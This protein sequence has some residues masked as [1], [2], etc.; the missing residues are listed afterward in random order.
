MAKV[1]IVGKPNVG[2]STLFNALIRKNKSL[3]LNIPGTTRDRIFEYGN[4]SG[5]DILFIDTGGFYKTGEL[6]ENINE[7]VKHA[8][9]A[10]DVVIIVFDLTTPLSIEDEEIFKYVLKKNKKYILIANKTDV[11]KQEFE[12][13]YYKFGDILKVSAAHRKNIDVLKEKIANL[14]ESS[15]KRIECDARVAIVGRSNVGKSS[16]INAILKEN[17]SV[18]SDRVGTTTDSID[19]PFYYREHCLMLVDTAGIRR[20]AKTKKSL[21]KL[22]SIFSIFAID[23]SDICIVLIDASEGLT[24]TDKHIIN[25]VIE[26]NKGIIIALNKWDMIKD[27]T[28]DEYAKVIRRE[29]PMATHAEILHISAKEGKNIKKL[30]NKV[31]TV[32][33]KC[34]NRIPTHLLN[35]KLHTI[36]K[37]NAPFSRKGKEIKLKYITQVDTNPPHFVIFTN[38]P[39]DIEDTY[40]RYIRNSLYKLFDFKGCTIKITYRRT[41]NERAS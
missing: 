7:Q 37:Q 3:I 38:R 40:K 24:A 26:K 31:I 21:D 34:S 8:I 18:V 20:K 25:M 39:E 9:D 10:S 41:E 29:F 30:L 16:L 22:A 1:A 35:E 36:I 4:I 19:T 28:F 33:K 15:E 6:K 32:L 2:K 27:T 14:I 17:R 13:D 23:R 12:H 11:K 5:K